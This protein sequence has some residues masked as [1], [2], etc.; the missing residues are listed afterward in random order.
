MKGLLLQCGRV[1]PLLL[2]VGYM[3][4][5]YAIFVYGPFNWP[6][7]NLRSLSIF[8]YACIIAAIIGY[9]VGI[10]PGGRI[11]P[12]LPW[13]RFLWIGGIAQLLLM[14]PASYLYTYLWPWQAP[15]MMGCQSTAYINMLTTLAEPNPWRPYFALLRGVLAPF[16]ISVVPLAI[17]HWSQLRRREYV[18]VALYVLSVLG[19]SYLRGTD[20]ETGDLIM[21]LLAMIPLVAYRALVMHNLYMQQM[22]VFGL[23]VAVALAAFSAQFLA[24]KDARMHNTY[25]AIAAEHDDSCRLAETWCLCRREKLFIA[26]DRT[27]LGALDPQIDHLDRDLD[28]EARLMKDDRFM[29]A[30]VNEARKNQ[31]IARTQIAV[32]IKPPKHGERSASAQRQFYMNT[33]AG[34]LSQGYFGLSLAMKEPF[35]TTYGLGHSPL[36]IEKLGGPLHLDLQGRSYT[37]KIS[38]RWHYQQHW[39]TAFTWIANDVGFPG[40][41]LVMALFAYGLAKAWRQA[42][43]REDDTSS[44]VYM[45]MLMAIFY[46]PANNQMLATIDSYCTTLFW[47]G[48][49]LLMRYRARK[50]A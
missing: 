50:Q 23:C 7:T 15:E 24:R 36:L 21:V 34:Y 47:L 35:T 16:T 13:R 43:E 9:M 37:G 30:L 44:I 33:I 3:A 4:L 31:A 39:S 8:I 46:L 10:R 14:T 26:P 38:D 2:L 19:M 40:T 5:T 48:Y 29:M 11:M 45:L 41:V 28:K 17:L 25:P 42:T 20:K 49:W 18:L 12:V 22:L 32:A 6:V 1:L 27:D